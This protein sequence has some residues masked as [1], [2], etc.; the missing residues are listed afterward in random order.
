MPAMIILAFQND[1]KPSIGRV[2]RL[3]AWW[4]CSTRLLRYLE[5]RNSILKDLTKPIATKVPDCYV[6]DTLDGVRRVR[7]D[8]LLRFF[9]GGGYFHQTNV[10][11]PVRRF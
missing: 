4:S 9:G 1:L 10:F 8:W 11:S 7:A 3:M 5:G 2:I 6:F